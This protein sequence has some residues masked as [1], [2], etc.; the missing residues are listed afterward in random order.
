MRELALIAALEQVLANDQPRVVR[1]IGDD[2]AV[3]RARPYAV[4]S[5]DTMV[6]G[7]HFPSLGGRCA[8][9]DVGHRALAGALSDLAAMGAEAGEAYLALVLPAGL[10]E[11]DVLALFEAAQALAA[12]TGT[13]IAGGDVA[14]GPALM[15]AVTVVGWADDAEV[16]V[17]RDG[18]QPG[19]L[20]GVTGTLGDAGAGL[21]V[22]EGRAQG[23]EELVE[24][25][26]RPLPRLAE[27]RALAAA[28]AHA[29][30][31]L[32]DGLATDARHLAQRSGVRIAV[33]LDRLPLAR[34]TVGVAHA[35]G[36]QPAAFAASAGEDYELCVCV[37]PS[38]RTAAEAAA[39]LTWIG[40]VEA[41]EPALDLGVAGA[42]LRGYEHEL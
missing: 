35:L 2:A 13:T 33:E 32:S 36:Q 41:G 38:A 17:G 28:G 26:L 8:P 5:V 37:P 25:Y 11:L 24:R 14:R 29:M 7:V 6:E 4:T 15:L 16:L 10:G 42:A 40:T 20:V 34:G 18:A 19:D 23:P 27:G 30:I 22:L 21:A 3:V 12:E 39:P 9:A 31:D 1:W